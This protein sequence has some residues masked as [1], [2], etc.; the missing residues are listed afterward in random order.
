VGNVVI[1]KS[2]MPSRIQENYQASK[3]NLDLDDI[4]QILKLDKGFRVGP[5]PLQIK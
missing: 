4:A 3:V 5:D 1:P 2:A